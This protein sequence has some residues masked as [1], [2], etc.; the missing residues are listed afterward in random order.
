MSGGFLKRAGLGGF[1]RTGYMS[2][3]FLKGERFGQAFKKGAFERSFIQGEGLRG[4]LR[5]GY[6]S[7]GFLKGERFGGFLNTRFYADWTA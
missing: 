6:L 3:V 4:F 2:C 5:T 1:L 7:G